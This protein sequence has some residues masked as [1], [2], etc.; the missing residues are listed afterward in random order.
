MLP[1]ESKGDKPS[2]AEYRARFKGKEFD[3]AIMR[4]ARG[5]VKT[6]RTLQGSCAAKMLDPSFITDHDAGD[7][8]CIVQVALLG[9]IVY[10]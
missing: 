10:A 9:H 8:D 7:D 6:N 5:E 4:I 2:K 3:K 1:V